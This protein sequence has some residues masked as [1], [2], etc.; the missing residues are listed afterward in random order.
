MS[1]INHPW[2]EVITDYAVVS[3]S[4]TK[5]CRYTNEVDARRWCVLVNSRYDRTH[6]VY[7]HGL[8]NRLG[9]YHDGCWFTPDE[10]D[11]LRGS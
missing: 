1:L 8:R 4:G 10:F 9:V 2:D 5:L 6:V 3:S 7:G 11:T